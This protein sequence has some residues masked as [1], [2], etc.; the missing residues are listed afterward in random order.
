MKNDMSHDEYEKAA[1]YWKLKDA[2]SVHA[3][4]K[5]LMSEIEAF[6]DKNDTCALATG[7]GEF[8]RCT[9]IQYTYHDSAFWLF[10]EGGEKFISLEHNKNVCIAIFDKF[11]GF[12]HL[13]GMQISGTAQI[14]ETF[15]EQ[16]IKAANFKKLPIEA[17]RKMPEPIH[18]IKIIP[19]KIDFL[20]SD[21]KKQGLD[22]RQSIIINK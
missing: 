4:T 13:K 9:P 8:V 22:S 21:F 10:T 12:G 20:N 18:L 16:Y 19:E 1:N 17:L 7:F 6:I 15:S 14:I 5:M 3:D 2:D 11:S